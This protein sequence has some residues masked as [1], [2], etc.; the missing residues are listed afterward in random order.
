MGVLRAFVDCD[1]CEETYDG[2]WPAPDED[3]EQDQDEA[4]IAEQ[5]CPNCGHRQ[6]EEFPGWSFHT[7][8]G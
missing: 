7:E 5:V 4:P 3:E 6:T 8:A 2:Y 1:D